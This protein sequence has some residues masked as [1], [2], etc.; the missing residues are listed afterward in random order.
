MTNFS[1]A[2]EGTL[3]TEEESIYGSSGYRRKKDSII[4]CRRKPRCDGERRKYS[5][6]SEI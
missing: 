5:G 3:S 1:L 6:E 4:R 2:V